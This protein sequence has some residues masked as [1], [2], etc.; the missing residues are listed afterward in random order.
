MM[1][2]VTTVLNADTFAATPAMND[3]ISPVSAMPSMPLGRYSFISSGMALLYS[4]FGSPPPR[5]LIFHSAIMPGTTTTKGIS[6]LGN[7]PISGVR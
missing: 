1:S 6:S 4:R 5:P 7:A 2:V 3:A